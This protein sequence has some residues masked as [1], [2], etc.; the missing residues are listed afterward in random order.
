MSEYE[1]SVFVSYSRGGESE[2]IVNQ[3]DQ[4]L[5]AR[6]IKLV[7]DKRDLGYKGSISEFMERIARGSCIVVVISDEYLRSHDR[8][9]ELVGI[10]KNK[11]FYDRVFPIILSDADI[12][13]AV[14]RL[15]YIKYW[16]EQIK[17]LDE[18]MKSVGSAKLQGVREEIDRYDDIRDEISGL[19]STLKDMNA[20]TPEMHRESNFN[21]LYTAIEKQLKETAQLALPEAARKTIQLLPFEPETVYIPEGP[22]WMGSPGGED[23]PDFETPSGRVQLPA[24]RIGKFP[25]TNKEY[26]VFMRKTGRS[27][28]D[29]GWRSHKIPDGAE[30]HPVTGVTWYDALAYCRWLS[31]QTQNKRQYSLPSEAQW[32]KACRGGKQTFFP[33]GDEFDETR[34]N[35]GRSQLAPVEHYGAQNEYGCYDLVG[36]VRQWTRSLWGT[37]YAGPDSEYAYPWED[38]QDQQDAY[39]WE[40]E[41]DD[42]EASRLVWRVLRGSS[43]G[44]ERSLLRCSY[45]CGDSPESRGYPGSRYGFRVVMTGE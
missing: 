27:A 34:C 10:A 14:N 29:I 17:E 40:E 23:I 42:L 9:F 11:D 26:A 21:D 15:K 1:P 18:A 13:R 44:D 2:E 30:Y 43:Y 6:G 37:N 35:Q 31:E 20:L 41:R 19:T 4:A 5:Q 38:G 32:E 28:L 16:E 22:F 36:N 45:K 39:S 12:Y 8:M 7:R 24:Y 25:V 33:W 3:L